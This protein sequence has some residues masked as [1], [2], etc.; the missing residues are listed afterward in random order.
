MT[1]SPV[2]LQVVGDAVP[3]AVLL[4]WKTRLANQ[5]QLLYAA[6]TGSFRVGFKT[7]E[8]KRADGGDFTTSSGLLCWSGQ[9]TNTS[10]VAQVR[11]AIA[12]CNNVEDGDV[13]VSGTS[14]DESYVVVTFRGQYAGLRVDLLQLDLGIGV[15]ASVETLPV[16][17]ELG[18]HPQTQYHHAQVW[19]GGF[20]VGTLK[21]EGRVAGNQLLYPSQVGTVYFM[22]VRVISDLGETSDWVAADPVTG[23]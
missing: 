1:R 21:F 20:D 14:L 7:P 22:R 8:G 10:T 15:E 18:I 3:G 6:G 4:L 23:I 12:Q 2:P 17:N 5:V 11:D 13:G 19:T 9:L 16:E